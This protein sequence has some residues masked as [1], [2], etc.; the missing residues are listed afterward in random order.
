VAGLHWFDYYRD[1]VEALAGSNTLTE[2][3]TLKYE[4]PISS[5]KSSSKDVIRSQVTKGIRLKSIRAGAYKDRN[6]VIAVGGRVT[7]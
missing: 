4:M 2:L 1:D 5:G 7:Y 3:L 6:Q